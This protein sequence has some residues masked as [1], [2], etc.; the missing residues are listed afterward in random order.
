MPT[1]TPTF[2]PRAT[3]RDRGR[4]MSFRWARCAAIRDV[5]TV[6]GL[7]VGTGA[8]GGRDLN[9]RP[10]D[11]KQRQVKGSTWAISCL[12]WSQRWWVSVCHGLRR[13][14]RDDRLPDF[15]PAGVPV[16]AAGELTHGL[17]PRVDTACALTVRCLT[18]RVASSLY[19]SKRLASQQHQQRSRKPPEDPGDHGCHQVLVRRRQTQSERGETSDGHRQPAGAVDLPA[20]DR[21]PHHSGKTP[22]NYEGDDETH[23]VVVTRSVTRQVPR[24]DD[25]D[26]DTNRRKHRYSRPVRSHACSVPRS[27]CRMGSQPRQASVAELE[28]RRRVV[29]ESA[30]CKIVSRLSPP[31]GASLG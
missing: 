16:Q 9:P 27:D 29:L 11:P 14:K 30:A 20:A 22:G 26:R 5:A 15:S 6:A 4:F 8:L 1:R 21:E 10:H 12:R 25:G 18:N 28:M 17:L 7:V 31:C 24:C 23:V 19:R 3:L 13:T 2:T